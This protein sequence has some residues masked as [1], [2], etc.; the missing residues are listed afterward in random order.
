LQWIRIHQRIT[1][2][3]FTKHYHLLNTLSLLDY[4]RVMLY[5][6][7]VNSFPSEMKKE[8]LQGYSLPLLPL[9]TEEDHEKFVPVPVIEL[10]KMMKD[11]VI[12]SLS[13]K[14][15]HLS[16]RYEVMKSFL[17][18]NDYVSCVLYEKDQMISFLQLTYLNDYYFSQYPPPIKRFKRLKRYLY[19]MNF[20]NIPFIWVRANDLLTDPLNAQNRIEKK[21]KRKLDST[22]SLISNSI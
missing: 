10:E 20:P 19:T 6:D 14:Y 7:L 21:I 1:K 15:P 4:N 18:S 16:F 3:F 22:N 11:K 5:F 17:K 9:S 13:S 2:E 8:I 12:P